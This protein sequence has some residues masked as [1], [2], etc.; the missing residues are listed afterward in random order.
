MSYAGMSCAIKWGELLKISK[1]TVDREMHR[2]LSRLFPGVDVPK[3]LESKY[4]YWK[5]G[6]S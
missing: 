1:E 4:I 3:P 5:E 6:Y 2:A